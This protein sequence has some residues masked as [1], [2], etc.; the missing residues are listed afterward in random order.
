MP[1]MLVRYIVRSLAALALLTTELVSQAAP[2][3]PEGGV[4]VP[5]GA[6]SSAVPQLPDEAAALLAQ[7]YSLAR[8]F[9]P[10]DRAFYLF[11]LASAYASA[12]QAE[13]T[14][15]YSLE[16]FQLA[17]GLP[18][19]WTKTAL[20][21]NALVVLAGVNPE[22]AVDMLGEIDQPP[23]EAGR[24]TGI[25]SEDLRADAAR[26]IFAKCWNKHD[27]QSLDRI[28]ASAARSTQ[29]ASTRLQPWRQSSPTF[30]PKIRTA[31]CGS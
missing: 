22:R 13:A 24:R 2:T 23:L 8:D 17:S 5:H 9:A 3:E 27:P 6:E 11:R 29:R 21:K 15:R 4:L 1:Q 28:V 10:L 7:S 16:M 18:A 12:G 19:S 14:E 20:Q 30:L 25:A 31:L 26:T